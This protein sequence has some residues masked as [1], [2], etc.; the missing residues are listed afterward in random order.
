MRTDQAKRDI[1]KY[2]EFHRDHGHLRN[3]CI[4]LKKEIEFLIRCRH[5]HCHVAPEDRNQAPPPPP[6]QLASAQHQQPL[7]EKSM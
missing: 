2:R 5:L 7:R 4:Q 6:R 3:G 1:T